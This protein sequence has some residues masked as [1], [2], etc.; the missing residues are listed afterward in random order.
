[1]SLKSGVPIAPIRF[2][3]SRYMELKGWD[4]KR[5]PYP[6]ARIRAEFSEPILVTEENFDE[7]REQLE[8]ALG[9]PG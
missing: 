7:A 9:V 2:S 3:V 8:K 6:F 5:F 4:R 1:M